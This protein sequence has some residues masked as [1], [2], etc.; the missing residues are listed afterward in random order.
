MRSGSHFFSLRPASLSVSLC[1]SLRVNLYTLRGSSYTRFDHLSLSLCVCVCVCVCVCCVCVCFFL[2]ILLSVCLHPSVF[3]SSSLPICFSTRASLSAEQLAQ[4][5]PAHLPASWTVCQPDNIDR[6]V[7]ARVLQARETSVANGT[8]STQQITPAMLLHFQ[9]AT[10]HVS[11]LNFARPLVC[12]HC[13]SMTH[14]LLYM[15]IPRAVRLLP[16]ATCAPTLSLLCPA[17]CWLAARH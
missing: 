12:A 3:L 13:Y 1:L 16:A 7:R 14:V 15:S 11:C 8:H 17:T 2:S 5:Q 10:H 6:N 9:P 4:Q